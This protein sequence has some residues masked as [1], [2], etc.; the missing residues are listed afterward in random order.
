[1]YCPKP[2]SL[3]SINCLD[4]VKD[5]FSKQLIELKLKGF[6]FR[7]EVIGRMVFT[8]LDVQ[9]D[10]DDN[11]E[12]YVIDVLFEGEA[13][14]SDRTYQIATADMFTF[15]RLLPGIA[16]AS[17]TTLFLPEF[18]RELLVQTLIEWRDN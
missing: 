1:M 3:S 5:A 14:Q 12:E 2:F 7:G 17:V 4:V 18:I 8:N 6:G 16:N 13:V 10:L 11:G 15:G 9:T